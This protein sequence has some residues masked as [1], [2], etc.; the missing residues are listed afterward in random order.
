MGDQVILVLEDPLLVAS[1]LVSGETPTLFALPV[2]AAVLMDV[3]PAALLWVAWVAVS[4]INVSPKLILIST[5]LLTLMFV[6]ILLL[7]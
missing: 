5:S 2:P 1:G 3:G 7:I 6:L 4:N